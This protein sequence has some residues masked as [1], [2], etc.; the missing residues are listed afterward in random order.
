MPRHH[1]R[2]VRRF[3]CDTTSTILAVRT[4]NIVDIAATE[5]QMFII[6]EVLDHRWRNSKLGRKGKVASNLDLLIKWKNYLEPS[7]N[8]YNE[9]SIKRVQVVIDYLAK[10]GLKYLIPASFKRKTREQD[11]ELG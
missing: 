8:I 9:A 5:R 2:K 7:W 1:Y 6:E 3:S 10:Q 11:N 4:R